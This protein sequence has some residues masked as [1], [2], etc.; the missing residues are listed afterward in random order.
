LPSAAVGELGS[1]DGLSGSGIGPPKVVVKLLH[2]FDSGSGTP[3]SVK[4]IV[5]YVFT[6]PNLPGDDSTVG[7]GRVTIWFQRG[8]FQ[9]DQFD[10]TQRYA[11][12]A[13]LFVNAEGKFTTHQASPNLP[14]VAMVTGPPTGINE[15]LEFLWF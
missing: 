11:V 2:N 13:T 15:T 7:S 4:A 6:V 8:I 5:N 9:T 3:N 1:L 12:N 10:T 14:G